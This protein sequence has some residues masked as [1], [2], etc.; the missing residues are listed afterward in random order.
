MKSIEKRFQMIS[1]KNPYW[2]T[3]SCFVETVR[4]QNFS[5]QT[6]C[7]WFNKLVE[8]DD[9]DKKDKKQ[10]LAFHQTVNK[11]SVDNKKK[12]KRAIFMVYNDRCYD[13][14]MD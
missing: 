4:G 2:S 3:N 7:R 14:D 6:V 9:Y 10:V 12:G 1:K 11:E 5:E 8:K 13:P